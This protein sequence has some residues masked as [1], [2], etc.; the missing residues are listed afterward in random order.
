MDAKESSDSTCVQISSR[1]AC[2]F[3]VG[4]FHWM[5]ARKSG[6]IFHWDSRGVPLRTLNSRLSRAAA[7]TNISDKTWRPLPR[8]RYKYIKS[9]N[10]PKWRPVACGASPFSTCRLS[11]VVCRATR[12]TSRR[13][14]KSAKQRGTSFD[15]HNCVLMSSLL[16][17]ALLLSFW[18]FPFDSVMSRVR[19]IHD[20]DD[21][22]RAH[23][24]R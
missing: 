22:G 1:A 14:R 11:A 9:G 5:A 24:R 23:W 18:V 8:H 2:I 15:E 12:E 16:S 7:K 4:L 19:T 3:Q 17:S 6:I 21:R 10:H 20:L 13:A